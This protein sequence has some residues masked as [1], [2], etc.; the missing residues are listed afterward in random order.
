MAST[1]IDLGLIEDQVVLGMHLYMPGGVELCSKA[2]ARTYG[3]RCIRRVD[4]NVSR[5]VDSALVAIGS[6]ISAL[7]NQL[8]ALRHDTAAKY[9]GSRRCVDAI[10]CAHGVGENHIAAADQAHLAGCV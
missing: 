5:L 7:Q 1:C 4:A 2:I 10:G 6:H 3:D 8:T 9:A